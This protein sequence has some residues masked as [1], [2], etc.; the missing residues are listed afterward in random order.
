MP[1]HA[2]THDTHTD[3]H[4]CALRLG[5]TALRQLVV[6]QPALLTYTPATLAGNLA[7]MGRCLVSGWSSD[8]LSYRALRENS[9]M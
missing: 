9:N 7:A 5:D 8:V 3:T 1:M 4:T 2:L 6:K